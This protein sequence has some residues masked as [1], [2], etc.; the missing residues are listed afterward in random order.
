ML[1]QLRKRARETRGLTLI[2]LLVV[3]L[4]F[5]IVAA[6]SIPSLANQRSRSPDAAAKEAAVTAARVI[7]ACASDNDGFYTAC[8]K[9]T[10]QSIEPT[11]KDFDARLAVTSTDT[12]YAIVVV[13]DRDAGAVSFTYAK[14]ADG[15]TTRDCAHGGA[16]RGGC[17]GS[18]TW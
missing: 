8:D 16:K 3:L 5:G 9:A 1:G 4:V 14:H 2:E 18:N 11:L 15:T 17:S 6:I 13:S 7:E 12:D 10:V